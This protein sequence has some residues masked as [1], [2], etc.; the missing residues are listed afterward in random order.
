M[1]IYICIYI[2]KGSPKAIYKQVVSTLFFISPL[3]QKLVH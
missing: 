3:M 1:H 2:L